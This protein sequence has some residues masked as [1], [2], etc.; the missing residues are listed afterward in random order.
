MNATEL[1]QS[2]TAKQIDD[3]VF[4][5]KRLLAQRSRSRTGR[6]IN[7][8][9]LD[10]RKYWPVCQVLHKAEA[11]NR[12]GD[13]K[14][15]EF[16]R[17]MAAGLCGVIRLMAAKEL[18]QILRPRLEPPDPA[19]GRCADNTDPDTEAD[20]SDA[21]HKFSAKDLAGYLEA[22]GVKCLVSEE[23][24]IITATLGLDKMVF[25][26]LLAFVKESPGV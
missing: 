3:I 9:F 18:E 10:D 2:L 22:D 5:F 8:C 4:D 13:K 1:I 14:Q 15:K 7:D 23:D 19:S 17:G 16:F 26:Q 11:A 25:V 24:D 21:T 20:I 6:E 12:A